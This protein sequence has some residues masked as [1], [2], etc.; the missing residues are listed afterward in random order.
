MLQLVGV[1]ARQYLFDAGALTA[2]FS[3]LLVVRREHV[4]DALRVERAVLVGGVKVF[5]QA[6]RAVGI[7]IRV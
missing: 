3:V 1:P 7:E 4:L 2:A 6:V 5:P